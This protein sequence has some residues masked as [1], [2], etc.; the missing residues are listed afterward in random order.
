MTAQQA[1]L[2]DNVSEKSVLGDGRNVTSLCIYLLIHSFIHLFHKYRVLP[3][4]EEQLH[5][6]VTQSAVAT[7][8]QV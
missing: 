6:E 1:S 4:R 2:E 5:S 7:K 8:R 3:V